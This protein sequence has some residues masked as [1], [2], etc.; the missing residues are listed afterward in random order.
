MLTF[1][2]VQAFDLDIENRIWVDLNSGAHFHELSQTNL[3]L[4]LNGAVL[5]AE[6]RVVGLFFQVDELVQ[7]VGPLFLQGFVQQAGQQRVALLDPATRRDAVGHVVE[8]GRPQLVIFREQIFDHQI[9]VQRR[10]AVNG[11]AA[12]HAHV[13]H[14][15]L[16]VV[17]HRQLRPDGFVAR[18][19]FLHQRFELVVNLIDDLHMARQ[20]RFHQL[21]IP[22]L[23]RFRHQGVVG[24]GEGAAGDGPGVVPAQLMLVDQHAQQFRDGNGRMRIVK[25]NNFEVRQL[26]QLAARQVVS[27]QNVRHGAGALEV[28]LHQTQ[29]FTRQMIIVRIE[30]FSQ[31][32]GVDPLLL[33][34]QEVTVVEFGQVKRMRVL[35]LPQTQRLRHAVT[36]AEYRQVPGFTGNGERRFPESLLRDFPANPDLHIQLRVV[37]EPRIGIAVPVVR[38]FHLMAVGK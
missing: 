21:L 14:T 36:V 13:R 3:V 24:V 2:L 37:A 20:Q 6:L 15:H 23:Q 1:V 4:Q 7:V 22:A 9:R 35:R 31:L 33:G 26:S 29:L 25:L 30:D 32:L 11:K 19:G 38:R 28:L 17:H 5:L 18:P 12:H 27:T 8:L 10:H 16:F 34:A